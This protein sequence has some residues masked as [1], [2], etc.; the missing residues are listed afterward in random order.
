MLLARIDNFLRLEDS[1]SMKNRDIVPIPLARR[2]W[3]MMSYLS[4]WSIICL[5][6]STWTGAAA[7]YDLGLNGP[8]SL[9]VVIVG[10][11]IITAISICNSLYG[12]EY[13]IGYSVFQRILWGTNGAWF[14]VLLRSL[15]SVV[16]FAAQ[17]WMGAL[18]VN[19]VLSTFSSSYLNMKNTFPDSVGFRPDELIGFVIFLLLE[20]PLLF[21]KPEYFDLMLIVS[22]VVT[23]VASFALTLWVCIMVGNQGT[24]MRAPITLSRSEH[25][26]AWIFGINTWYSGLVA[27][28]ANQSDYSRFNRRPSHSH[29]G[30]ILGINIA[31]IF[32]PLLALF[33]TSSFAW[34]YEQTVVTPA[35]ICLL[36]MKEDYT[37]GVRAACFFL[38]LCFVVSQLSVTTVANAIPGGMDLS[39][40]FPKYINTRRGA[41]IVFLL[42]WPSQP[43]TYYSS[44]KAF[45]DVMSSF[46]VFITPII[47][48]SVCEYYVVRNREIKLSD[49]YIRGPQSLYW[50]C[51][52]INFKSIFCFIAGSA[53][54]VPGLIKTANPKA[55][56]S[57]GI[58]DFYK[59]G[60]IFQFLITFAMYWIAN[61]IFPSPVDGRDEADYFNTF[62]EEERK[63]WNIAGADEKEEAELD[64]SSY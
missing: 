55:K 51:R 3:N 5:C 26:W 41:L 54:G 30:T 9:G 33:C 37:P 62:T 47:A 15:L 60:F 64:A 28:L 57:K 18:C 13:H 46:S 32:V 59:G 27:G 31:G 43:W 20:L 63:R 12:S 40:I 19:V 50:Y 22:S 4:Y 56:M 23:L 52:G 14:G 2:R 8:Q 16:W 34:K 49:C 24:L 1:N 42:A 61:L 39:T 7:L 6:M 29:W 48:M 35:D 11:A 38:G 53:L 10:N 36:I 45:L 25:A 44:G 21:I 17:A 58:Y